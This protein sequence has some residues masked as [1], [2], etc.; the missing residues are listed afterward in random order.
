MV[1]WLWKSA[2]GEPKGRGGSMKKTLVVMI[3]LGV[4]SIA[5][6]KASRLQDEP[7]GAKQDMKDAGHDTKQAAKKTGNA[8]EKSTKKAAHESATAAKKTGSA[9]ENTTKK[10]TH[11]S[12]HEVKKGTAKVEGKTAPQ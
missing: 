8:V 12:A 4:A 11:E 9:V 6:A 3:L 5:L 2:R 10:A 7:E 1:N